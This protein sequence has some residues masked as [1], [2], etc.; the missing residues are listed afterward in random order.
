MP[1]KNAV[2]VDIAYTMQR[3][4]VIDAVVIDKLKKEV[5]VRVK[6]N[7]IKRQAND[8]SLQPIKVTDFKYPSGK[9]RIPVNAIN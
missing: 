5:V 3:D 8:A 6:I 1:D 2:F 9:F 7:S 4:T